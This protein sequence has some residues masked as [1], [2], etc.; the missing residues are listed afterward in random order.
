MY[1]HL[2]NNN[3]V[4]K[5]NIIG[6]FNYKVVKNNISEKIMNKEQVEEEKIKS[7]IVIQENNEIKNYIS[8]ISTNTLRKRN[9]KKGID[10]LE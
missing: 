5:K 10:F 3:I 8:N 7:V 6:F 4:N 9:L 1:I 2:G